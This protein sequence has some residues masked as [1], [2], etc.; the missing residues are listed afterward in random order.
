M[1]WYDSSLLEYAAENTGKEFT[2]VSEERVAFVASVV[3][4]KLQSQ[5]KAIDTGQEKKNMGHY[6]LGNI[7]II[8]F[9]V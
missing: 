7:R 6:F 8:V 5:T 9:I 1:T 3:Q 2:T 4:Y